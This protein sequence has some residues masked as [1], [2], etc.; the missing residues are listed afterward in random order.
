MRSVRALKHKNNVQLAMTKWL[1]GGI[2]ILAFLLRVPFLDLYPIGFNADE[3]SF[4]YDAY[5][6]LHT[7]KDQWG[8][9]LPLM[10]ESFGDFKTPLYSYLDIPFVGIFGLTKI[11]TRL[12]GAL[13]GVGAVLLVYLVAC[14]LV[15]HPAL[16]SGSASKFG[17]GK[18]QIPDQVRHD[19]IVGLTSAFLLAISPW[20]IQLSRGAFESNLTSFFLPLGILLFLKGLKNIKYFQWS[21]FVFGLN[22]FSYHSSKVVTPLVVGFLLIIY[23][24]ELLAFMSLRGTKQSRNDGDRHANARDDKMVHISLMLSS[25]IFAIF[26]LLTALTL[27]QGAGRRA[28]DVSIFG[29]ALE[30]QASA[31]LAAI[32]SGTSPTVARLMHN[33][34]FVIA[35]RFFYNYRSY[36]NPDFLFK[37]GVREGTY[38]MVPGIPVMYLFELPLLLVFLW[39]AFRNRKEKYIQFIFFWLLVAPI[40]AALTQGVGNAGNRAATMLPVLQIASGIG[41]LAMYQFISRKISKPLSRV[42]IFISFIV[43]LVSLIKFTGNY[44]IS[45]AK[46]APSMLYGDLEVGYWLSENAREYSKV[47]VS[48]KL[49]EPHIFIAFAEAWD[50]TDYQKSTVEWRR[51]REENLKFL[52]QLDGYS[53]GKYTFGSIYPDDFTRYN[54]LLVGR[55]DEFPKESTLIKK[56]TYPDGKDSIWIVKSN[57]IVFAYE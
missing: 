30:S 35:D 19:E 52:D 49:S 56:F 26:M 14:L 10:L 16:V 23:R 24:K 36:F 18:R 37:N 2:L 7:G 55:P 48:R 20:H 12:P 11:A 17:T 4:G 9:V 53:L 54:T 27:L 42:A 25:T 29:G 15:R 13:L 39:Y 40:P 41:A 51:Y 47:I 31:R 8:H 32:E 44:I 50:L 28:A 21:A 34:Y 38:G 57:G 46:H 6:L 1:I 3:A 22:L 5:S 33:K 45:P 43:V